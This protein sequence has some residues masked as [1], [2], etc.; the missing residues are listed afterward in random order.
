MKSSF[1]V[2][3]LCSC[4]AIS[5]NAQEKTFTDSAI[6][7]KFNSACIKVGVKLVEAARKGKI[8][9]C[10]NDSLTH[11][12]AMNGPDKKVGNFNLPESVTG[13]DI[14][15]QQDENLESAEQNM[16][17]AGVGILYEPVI[18]G[19]VLPQ[20]AMYYIRYADLAG[21]LKEDEIRLITILSKLMFSTHDVYHIFSPEDGPEREKQDMD[22]LVSSQIY[23][24]IRR[25][26]NHVFLLKE[27][28]E[29][30]SGP[31]ILTTSELF[32]F[33]LVYNN[34]TL[35]NVYPDSKL[36]TPYTNKTWSDKSSYCEI[37]Q[38]QISDDEDAIV[39]SLVCAN[40]DYESISKIILT[41]VAL[42]LKSEAVQPEYKL[43]EIYTALNNPQLRLPSWLEFIFKFL[44][45][46]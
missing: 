28:L 36:R 5:A 12:V 13:L 16:K 20:Q 22:N 32:F 21:V 27:N 42:G 45:S 35:Q 34:D 33:R 11:P 37:V 18:N 40:F 3:L 25:T 7:A 38:V 44:Y 9:A 41:P 15:F 39:D 17:L 30:L 29:R 31:L 46:N 43:V 4:L 14:V 6:A 24:N 10:T 23:T 2:G 26:A 19:I 1:L 8:E